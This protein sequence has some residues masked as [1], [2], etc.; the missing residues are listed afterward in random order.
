[1]SLLNEW[2]RMLT[3]ILL[4]WSVLHWVW[5]ITAGYVTHTWVVLYK[6]MKRTRKCIE[7]REWS[8][9]EQSWIVVVGLWFLLTASSLSCPH[10]RHIA[11]HRFWVSGHWHMMWCVRLLTR[12]LFLF[13][14]ATTLTWMCL[15]K[16]PWPIRWQFIKHT[17]HWA[18]HKRN[19]IQ[20]FSFN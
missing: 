9:V 12:L 15:T 4:H 7:M 1:M 19:I 20:T 3:V 18:S 5:C 8:R 6:R 16:M 2:T 17:S 13:D 10:R 14:A 11:S